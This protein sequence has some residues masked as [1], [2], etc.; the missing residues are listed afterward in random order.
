MPRDTELE[1]PQDLR[2]GFRKFLNL[3]NERKNMSTKTNFK[4]VALVAVA[5]LG[6]GVLTSVAP[7]NAATGDM[8]IGANA[9]AA[10][11]DVA[12]C[13]S[14]GIISGAGAVAATATPVMYD[15][16]TMAILLDNAAAKNVMT[17]SGGTFTA[18]NTAGTDPVLTGLTII[19]VDAAD[20]DFCVLAKPNAAG[21]PMVIKSYTAPTAKT[22]SSGGT[23]V[24]T[25][26][27]TVSLAANVG[28]FSASKSNIAITAAGAA[29]AAANIDTAG[30]NT[31][32]NG[33][34]VYL[35]YDL[36]DANSTPL[37][38][39]TSIIGKATSGFTVGIGA[40]GTI[41]VVTG[42]WWSSYISQGMP[43]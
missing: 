3:T 10:D 31:V 18:F 25:I 28:V 38:T 21:T 39:S 36:K 13:T 40:T 20:G 37:P 14:Y 9:G 19:G 17:I 34:C 23:L 16:G 15:S 29:P 11:V 24:D 4:R 1:D 6:L 41:G 22:S 35:Y 7:A 27:T 32:E 12:T 5:A 8:V 2:A 30:A 43:I 26:T 42:S 33:T